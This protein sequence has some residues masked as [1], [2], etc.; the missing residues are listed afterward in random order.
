MTEFEISLRE[1]KEFETSLYYNK[2]SHLKN[3]PNKQIKKQTKK[4]QTKPSQA[5]NSNKE[6]QTKEL[7]N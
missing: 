3:Q 4:P 2:W 7:S 6:P 1:H 5:N